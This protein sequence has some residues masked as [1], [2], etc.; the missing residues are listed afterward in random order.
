MQFNNVF[1]AKDVCSLDLLA[2][3]NAGAPDTCG[4][5]V[6]SHMTMNMCSKVHH[7]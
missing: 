7:S 1:V 5:E 2:V 4:L 6:F 3:V